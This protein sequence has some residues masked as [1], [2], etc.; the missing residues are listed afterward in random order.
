MGF[1]YRKRGKNGVNFSLSSRGARLSKTVKMGDVKV[2][3]GK[4]FGG[5]HNGKTTGSV[6]AGSN[7]V[8]YRKDFTLGNTKK[9]SVCVDAGNSNIAWVLFVLMVNAVAS[10]FYSNW[11]TKP[12]FQSIGIEYPVEVGSVP[13]LA[14]IITSIIMHTIPVVYFMAMRR[15]GGVGNMSQPPLF[16]L[17]ATI[18]VLSCLA[19]G[20]VAYQ[21]FAVI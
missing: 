19:V 14:N 5:T 7:G 15:D 10:I 11:L 3:L 2:N 4:Y 1:T 12:Y 20:Y 17:V 16:G 6:R 8:E 13:F 18:Y 9:N 21:A